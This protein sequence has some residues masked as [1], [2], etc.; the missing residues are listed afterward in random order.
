[1]L[2]G[3][4]RKGFSLVEVTVVMGIMALL[5]I[6]AVAAILLVKKTSLTDQAAEE[7]LS[8][9]RDVQNKSISVEYAPDKVTLPEVWGISISSVDKTMKIFYITDEGSYTSIHN[10][11][12]ITYNYLA[13]ISINSGAIT[14]YYAMYSTPFGRYYGATKSCG[15]NTGCSWV[16]NTIVPHD[17][18]YPSLSGGLINSQVNIILQSSNYSREIIVSAKGEAYAK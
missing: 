2:K 12:T 11:K 4:R 18:I 8:E 17:Y 7:I 14:D 1:M 9:I 16:Q 5:S 15:D 13:S 6:L 10:V 3:G